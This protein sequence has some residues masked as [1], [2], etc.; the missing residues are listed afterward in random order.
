MM[1]G[2]KPPLSQTDKL[3]LMALAGVVLTAKAM[4]GAVAVESV[5]CGEKMR[6]AVESGGHSKCV[7]V[8]R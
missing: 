7:P 5:Y 4:L 6:A 8:G 2:R 1:I 3:C